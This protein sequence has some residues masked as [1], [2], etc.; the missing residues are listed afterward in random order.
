MFYRR[1]CTRGKSTKC[2][3]LNKKYLPTPTKG[4]EDS[5][6][7][8]DIECVHF[9]TPIFLQCSHSK[10]DMIDNRNCII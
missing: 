1:I 10:D 2:F 7:L 4:P 3:F 9:L 6:Q 5:S 8:Y